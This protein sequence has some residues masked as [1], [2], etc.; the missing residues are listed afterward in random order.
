M[1]IIMVIWMVMIM[2]TCV[3]VPRLQRLLCGLGPRRPMQQEPSL[4][5]HL[6]CKGRDNLTMKR[7][8]ICLIHSSNI[9]F[10]NDVSSWKL[11]QNFQACK[12]CRVRSKCVDEG[13]SCPK[14]ARLGYCYSSQYK[15]YMKLKCKK[16]CK[17]CWIYVSLLTTLHTFTYIQYN[18][19][20]LTKIC[21]TVNFPMVFLHNPKWKTTVVVARILNTGSS[22]FCVSAFGKLGIGGCWLSSLG[23]KG[24]D[25]DMCWSLAKMSGKRRT[26]WRG[27]LEISEEEELDIA[28]ATHQPSLRGQETFDWK[29]KN[30]EVCCW[31]F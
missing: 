1:V 12:K 11:W 3:S 18:A 24:K 10:F 29:I 21:L 16:S 2:K 9:Y 5:G 8:K 4:Y 30:D 7:K 14:W 26:L 25:S 6:L 28:I 15:N 17:I 23:L 31:S 19:Y 13:G 27:S 22:C 20:I